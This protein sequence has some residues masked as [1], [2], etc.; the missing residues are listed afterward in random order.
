MTVETIDN[1]NQIKINMIDFLKKYVIRIYSIMLIG[2]AICEI[3]FVVMH[4]KNN[5]FM[6]VNI[7]SNFVFAIIGFTYSLNPFYNFS[8]N[9][10][11]FW[12]FEDV[13]NTGYSALRTKLFKSITSVA[14]N[15]VGIALY[16]IKQNSNEFMPLFIAEI[17]MNCMGPILLILKLTKIYFSSLFFPKIAP[18]DNPTENLSPIGK[19]FLMY[20]LR[21]IAIWIYFLCGYEIFV[22]YKINQNDICRERK[23][24]SVAILNLIAN[25]I[26]GSLLI[27]MPLNKFL[28]EDAKC[29]LLIKCA[30][31]SIPTFLIYVSTACPNPYLT[32]VFILEFGLHIVLPVCIFLLIMV[33]IPL[34]LLIKYLFK[35]I[36][37]VDDLAQN[38]VS[39]TANTV[40]TANTANIASTPTN[41]A[42]NNPTNPLQMLESNQQAQKSQQSQEP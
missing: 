33:L 12:K 23:A 39:N 24:V 9:Y 5:M 13:D 32:S 30:I 4:K 11:D 22:T 7:A 34:T 1:L 3:C 16:V 18:H 25:F 6:C 8:F 35:K 17:I 20:H 41:T 31:V 28:D 15:S 36:I 29:L 42:G 10:N 27:I 14:F 38:N 21:Y 2:L 26:I 40:N 37:L 19:H